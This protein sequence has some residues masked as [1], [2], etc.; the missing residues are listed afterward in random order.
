MTDVV[1]ATGS[2]GTAAG[3]ALGA[4]LA[5]ESAGEQAPAITAYAVCDTEEY[6]YDFC[7][8]LLDELAGAEAGYKSREL[9]AVRDAKGKGYA[10]ATDEELETVRAV[11][12]ATGVLLDPVYSGKALHGM[13]ADMRAD[14]DRWRGRKVVFLHTGGL[15]GMMDDSKLGQLLPLVGGVSRFA[16]FAK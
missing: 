6:F 13:L 10:V 14:P 8:G 9:M 2:G 11:A 16:D 4:R 3:L 1:L 7:Q 15:F 12:A 5:A